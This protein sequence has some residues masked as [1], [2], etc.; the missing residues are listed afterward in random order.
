[1]VLNIVSFLSSNV[2]TSPIAFQFKGDIKMGCLLF[3][4]DL[5]Q[6]PNFRSFPT[7]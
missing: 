5:G 4:L 2:L 6:M 7:S 1:M 3:I